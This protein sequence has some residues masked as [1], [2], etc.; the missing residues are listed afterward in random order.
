MKSFALLLLIIGAANAVNIFAAQV[1]AL[2]A[3]TNAIALNNEE[4]EAAWLD[5]V[6]PDFF[7]DSWCTSDFLH[8]FPDAACIA[9]PISAQEFYDF[10]V[11]F[12]AVIF[13]ATTSTIEM[14][15]EPF[16]TSGQDGYGVQRSA[17]DE[18]FP[19]GVTGH[20]NHLPM[21]IQVEL[22]NGKWKVIRWNL[23]QDTAFEQGLIC[24]A[25]TAFGFPDPPCDVSAPPPSAL[26]LEAG[27]S[28]KHFNI[29]AG[30][31]KFMELYN[32]RFE[33]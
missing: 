1:K 19:G 7:S 3:I 10:N 5:A 32:N 27:G 15:D 22:D 6:H 25:F 23:M 14:L 8:P 11:P 33:L 17:L 21:H 26:L 18:I 16:F 29:R 2:E 28:V 9:Q 12:F 13:N 20:V 24:R 4:G 31:A 30:R